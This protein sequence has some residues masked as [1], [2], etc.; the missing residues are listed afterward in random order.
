MS[1]FA[2]DL[3]VDGDM[4][5]VAVSY[6]DNKVLV[7]ENNPECLS[8]QLHVM[9]DGDIIDP[10]SVVV[11]NLDGN[12]YP[13]IVVS[14]TTTGKVYAIFDPGQ[15]GLDSAT[16]SEIYAP[17]ATTHS[18]SFVNC[19]LCGDSMLRAADFDGDGRDELVHVDMQSRIVKLLVLDEASNSY[20]AHTVYDYELRDSLEYFQVDNNPKIDVGDIDGDGKLDVVSFDSEGHL[21]LHTNTGEYNFT[22]TEIKP[23]GRPVSGG[24]LELQGYDVEVK[25]MNGDSRADIVVAFGSSVSFYYRVSNDTGW[26]YTPVSSGAERSVGVA[27]TTK[28]DIFEI[29]HG[30][31]YVKASLSQINSCPIGGALVERELDN[32]TE[33]FCEV[34]G[35]FGEPN[36][37]GYYLSRGA[38]GECYSHQCLPGTTDDDSNPANPC[39]AC[40]AGHYIPN[41]TSTGP[42]SGYECAVGTY[43]DDGDAAT[44]CV[45]CPAEAT[46][47]QSKS[48]GAASCFCTAGFFDDDRSADVFCRACPAHSSSQP[49]SVGLRCFAEHPHFFVV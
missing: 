6:H 4:D 48:V 46:T 18:V 22:R 17:A 11:A 27:V 10:R 23:N 24:N 13:D 12:S 32:K 8:F 14:S 39:V 26:I 37:V 25:D 21:D 38:S 5:V 33:T 35:G 15:G 34:C 28:S 20:T 16:T 41:R 44:A 29:S 19:K 30:A 7:Y 40:G 9:V 49:S 2:S 42:C 47:Y 36:L 43:D 45:S 1:V 31:P 3:D